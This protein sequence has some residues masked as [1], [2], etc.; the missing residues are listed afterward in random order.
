MAISFGSSSA[1]TLDKNLSYPWGLQ[2]SLCMFVEMTI[3]DA[4]SY[5]NKP[6]KELVNKNCVNP[7][8]VNVDIWILTP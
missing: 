7:K 3:K 2:M 6:I 5:K 4:I 1:R 8:P